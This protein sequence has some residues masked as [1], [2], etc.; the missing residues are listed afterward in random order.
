[1]SNKPDHI[2]LYSPGPVEVRREIL[3]AQNEW[4]IGHRGTPFADLYGRM[5]PKLQQSFR[6]QNRVYV[7]TSS[8]SGVWE[9]ASRNCVRDD[10]RVLHLVSGSFSDRWSKVSQDNGKQVDIIEVEWGKAILPEQLEEALKKQDYDAVACTYSETSTGVLHPLKEYGEVMKNYPDTLLLVDAVS[11]Y[12]GA[13]LHIDEWGVDLCL[14]S[15]QKAFGLPPGMAFGTVSERVLERAKQVKNRGYYFDLLV[16]EKSHQKNN[17]PATPPISLM[18]AADKQLD[19]MIAEGFEA[20]EA[21]HLKMA[22]MTRAWGLGAGFELFPQAGYE[23]VTLTVFK[24]TLNISIKDL[25][26]FLRQRGMEIA[27]GYDRIKD[28]TFR[29]A[30]MADLQP[31]HMQELF[32]NFDAFLAQ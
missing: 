24:N 12:A 8:G 3:E 27:N 9:A 31:S 11:A 1:M 26:N 18:F 13:P 2:R 32:D 4:M 6:T 14:T 29:I 20:R 21:R 7:F 22:E 17:T 23:G 15:T 16:M 30:H 5:Q 19:D 10:K 28:V 25:N